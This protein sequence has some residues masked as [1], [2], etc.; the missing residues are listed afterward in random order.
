VNIIRCIFN[1]IL[2]IFEPALS[3]AAQFLS[4]TG[5]SLE[6]KVPFPNTDQESENLMAIRKIQHLNGRITFLE[7]EFRVAA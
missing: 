4:I 7:S 1:S 3:L 6:G 2:V 5:Q